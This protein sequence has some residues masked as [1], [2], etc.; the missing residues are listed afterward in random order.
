MSKDCVWS[1]TVPVM[2]LLRQEAPE[3]PSRGDS[4]WSAASAGLRDPRSP[5]SCPRQRDLCFWWTAA[6]TWMPAPPS[7]SSL[8]R[9][10][11]SICATWQ[12]LRILALLLSMSARRKRRAMLSSRKSILCSKSARESILSATSRPGTYLPE[13]RTLLSAM[14]LSVM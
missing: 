13:K 11:P 2:P 12:E 1:K 14:P 10:V 8:R 7:W 4:S 5:R 3:R 6:P 9:W